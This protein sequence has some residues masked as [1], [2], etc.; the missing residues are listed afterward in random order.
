MVA[1]RWLRL[2]SRICHAGRSSSM[3]AVLPNSDYIGELEIIE[4]YEYLD[5]PKLF[6]CRNLSGQIYLGLW[7]GFT[8]QGESYW[9]VAMTTDRYLAVRSGGITL[10]RAFSQPESGIF[11]K[12]SIAFS[13]GRTTTEIFLAEQ[14]DN[15]LLP[16]AN[17][18]LAL[19]TQTLVTRFDRLDLPRK[20]I[21]SQRD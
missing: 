15:A 2:F 19:P 1:K 16:D 18:K 9:L 7:T 10:A 11:Y 21:S 8:S 13:N 12:C 3:I 20:A 14:I 5:G 6:A 4:V 17:E